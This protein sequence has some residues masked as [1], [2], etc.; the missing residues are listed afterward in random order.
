MRAGARA[1]AVLKGLVCHVAVFHWQALDTWQRRIGGCIRSDPRKLVRAP[2]EACMVGRAGGAGSAHVGVERALTGWSWVHAT[3]QCGCVPHGAVRLGRF[4][5]RCLGVTWRVVDDSVAL[6]GGVSGV[7]LAPESFGRS[8]SVPQ[9][10]VS[11]LDF[12]L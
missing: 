5:V 3:R 12:S 9:S 6:R 1:A 7:L 11:S 8:E 4:T 2:Q 10:V